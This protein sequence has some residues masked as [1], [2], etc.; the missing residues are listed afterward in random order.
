MALI[1]KKPENKF[2]KKTIMKYI[3]SLILVLATTMVHAQKE[4][5]DPHAEQRNVP[6]F[7][8]INVSNA[9]DVY[10][11]QGNENALA[12]SASDNEVKS[13]IE[14]YVKNNILYI[15]FDQDKKFWKGWNNNKMNL[16]AYISFKDLEKININGACNVIV[17]G[18]IK[19]NKLDIHL[20]GASDMKG[21]L[22][23]N[24]LGINLSGASD[25][26]I[27][28]TVTN[29]KIDVSGASEFKG[30]NMVT[31]FCNAE[32][33]GAS[34]IRITVNKELSVHASG[35][36]DVGYKGTGMIREIK[37]SGASNVSKRS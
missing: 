5:N 13:K 19:T 37:T 7:N 17:V 20:S 34:G 23:V 9:F 22:D 10:L 31:D 6:A 21:K 36:S 32:A 14:T 24:D 4:I 15:K 26:D 18:A 28:G 8:Q 2:L 29:A 12:V 35:A 30:F 3:L 25:M 27:T 1:L 11:V 16:K 33:S